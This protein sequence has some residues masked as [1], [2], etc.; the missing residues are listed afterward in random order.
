MTESYS[1]TSIGPIS[2]ESS[3][4]DQQVYNISPTFSGE[5]WLDTVLAHPNN[6]GIPDTGAAD[7]VPVTHPAH[8]AIGMWSKRLKA[9]VNDIRV[10]IA[11]TISSSP[12]RKE[13]ISRKPMIDPISV[14]RRFVPST[15]SHRVELVVPIDVRS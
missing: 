2:G 6:H 12:R 14:N 7:I 1:H 3:W 9:P 5:S 10:E 11:S 4:S 13:I 8:A 15:M